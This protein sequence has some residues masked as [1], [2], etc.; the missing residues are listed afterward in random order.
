MIT[1]FYGDQYLNAAALN[2]RGMGF[3]LDLLNITADNIHNIVQNLL[4]P[5]YTQTFIQFNN[6]YYIDTFITE[7]L[8]QP[9][10][11][12]MNIEID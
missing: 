10:R 9:K 1:P 12:H 5:K 4:Q 11:F 2:R 7:L 3:K 8:K 6:N